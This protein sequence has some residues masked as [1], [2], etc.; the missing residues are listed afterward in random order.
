M[1]ENVIDIKNMT[2]VYQMGDVEVRALAGVSFQVKKG[3]L[4]ALMGPSGS[5]KSTMMNMLGCLDIPTSGE[6]L[7]D[8]SRVSELNDNQLA[9]IRNQKVGFV[10]QR[11]MLLSNLTARGNVELPLRYAGV[12]SKERR[13]RAEKALQEVGLSDRMH[14]HSNELSGGQQQRVALARA[15]VNKPAILM[16]DEPTGNRVS[17]SGREVMELILR[18][19]KEEG[20][21]VIVVTHDSAIAAHCERTIHLFDGKIDHEEVHA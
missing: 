12:P 6:Y 9:D 7:L 5:G 3:E 17:K 14:H 11:F 16:A 8:G 4:V 1:T 20:S 2:K 19:N 10:F 18:L 13:Q 15:I 21:T